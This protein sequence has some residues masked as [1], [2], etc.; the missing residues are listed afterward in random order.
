MSLLLQS[1]PCERLN[2]RSAFL[3]QITQ[4]YMCKC[5][6]HV[7]F[8]KPKFPLCGQRKDKSIFSPDPPEKEKRILEH[9][10]VSAV[11]CSPITVTSCFLFLATRLA[12]RRSHSPRSTTQ[13]PP[14]I[15]HD[16]STT[17]SVRLFVA[18]P[19][20]TSQL[21]LQPSVSSRLATVERSSIS[22]RHK[23]SNLI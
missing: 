6:L 12:L 3:K 13:R 10:L 1:C 2:F 20:A 7:I 9:S 11:E 22:A 4:C 5:A 8:N 15:L 17:S 18:K 21:P 16:I 14:S 23:A 19:D